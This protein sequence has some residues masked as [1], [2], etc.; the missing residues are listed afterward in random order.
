MC[1]RFF[2][3]VHEVLSEKDWRMKGFMM[4]KKNSL[5]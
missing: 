5:A 4:I 3:L 2:V 1:A